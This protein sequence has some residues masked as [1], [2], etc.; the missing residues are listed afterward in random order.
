MK[1]LIV[2]DLEDLSA[3][4]RAFCEERDWT[5]FHNPKDLSIGMV[6][7]ASE[8]LELFRFQTNGQMTAMLNDCETRERIGDELA[9]QL[10]FLLRFSDLYGFDLSAELHRKIEKN[11]TKYPAKSSRGSNRK[12]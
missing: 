4:V 9:D 1:E 2:T 5:R 10:C 11:N 7:E 8:L 3:S 6:T 12:A